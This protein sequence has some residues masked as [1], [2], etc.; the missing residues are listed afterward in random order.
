MIYEVF[1]SN[2]TDENKYL[3]YPAD[4]NL[5]IFNAELNQKVGDAGEFTFSVPVTNF[6]YDSVIEKAIVTIN[7]D[8]KEY[9]RG[10]IREVSTDF[11]KTKTVVC[12]E[13]MA[14]L[15][16]VPISPVSDK[17]KNYL[18]RLEYAI[19]LYNT[20]IGNTK[21]Q[22]EIGFISNVPPTDS[23]NWYSDV[24]ENNVL[25]MIRECICQ[26]SGYVRVRRTNNKRYIDI[27]KL[28]D[29]G[30][31]NYQMIHFG[32]NLLDYADNLDC[33]SMC[34][35]LHPFGEE[36]E[37]E[38]IIEGVSK[39][40]E[41]T[42]IQNNSSIARYGRIEKNVVFETDSITT[43]NRLASAYLSRYSQPDIKME[44]T[45][46]D[47]A[48]FDVQY[49]S[50]EIGDRIRIVA[51]PFA[52]DMWL[53]IIEK[54]VDLQS[55]ENNTIVLSTDI[56]R[57]SLTDQTNAS[58]TEIEEIPTESSVVNAARRNAKKLLS[59][60]E[61]GNVVFGFN[62]DGQINE[63]FIADNLNVGLAQRVWRWNI[64]GWGYSD[65]GLDGEYK[66][67]ATMNGE[68]VA[69]FITTGT[70]S[71]DIVRGGLLALG[72]SAS[73]TFKEGRL[74]WY[75][76]QNRQIGLID[77]SGITIN[78]GRL[79]GAVATFQPKADGSLDAYI[80]IRD[81]NGFQVGYWEG[82]A[83]IN[84]QKGIIRN[85]SLEAN[86]ATLT[87]A[88]IT[89]GTVTSGL[90]V[91]PNATLGISGNAVVNESGTI[92]VNGG[93]GI[94]GTFS[95]IGASTIAKTGYLKS[96]GSFEVVEGSFD[97]SSK[98][99]ANVNGV[100]N[101]G[102]TLDVTGTLKA[103]GKKGLSGQLT[104][105]T[106]LTTEA[107]KVVDTVDFVYKTYTTKTIA[108]PTTITKRTISFDNGLF[109]A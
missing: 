91:S 85:V 47:L 90:T 32:D 92:T 51:E 100:L 98:A 25:N 43:L 24:Y 77:A 58:A 67:A 52:I 9:W 55:V 6:A 15:F 82:E 16:D 61:G 88:T 72:G 102:G 21:K 8:G 94:N 10:D 37:E 53:S 87:S 108:A 105:V 64:N 17:S 29:Y 50:I 20:S 48:L 73:G 34:N 12:V 76:S 66:L 71:A 42:S 103:N 22:F 56:K 106:N 93:M 54:T 75:D 81:R 39:R 28:E 59:G 44:L 60:A 19:N 107:I 63:L 5:V 13:D 26:D 69:D 7:K 86:S 40:I 101:V 11:Q 35:V 49:E 74:A 84:I 104:V 38:E 78:K 4:E 65:S 46:Y 2:L 27:V 83:G 18:Q 30:K 80:D 97:V 62:D 79:S 57:T 99:T 89:N 70:M 3:Y 95:I 23:C 1:I 109:T 68:I 36:L 41:G 14:W 45:A 96:Y 33:E 31:T